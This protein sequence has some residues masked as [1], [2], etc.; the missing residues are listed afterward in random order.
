MVAARADEQTSRGYWT[1]GRNDAE[2]SFRAA[3]KHSRRV[4]RLRV[5]VPAGLIVILGGMLLWSWL[6]PLHLL[7]RLPGRIGD[8]VISGTKITMQAPRLSGF[9][10][11]ARPYE[12]TAKSAAQD[13]T[14]P[15]IVE[16]R[17]IHA[18]VQTLS[19]GMTNITARDGLYDS[20]KEILTLGNDVVLVTA[21]YKAWLTNAVID[22]RSSN[23]VSDKPVKVEI[24]QGILN[25]NRLQVSESG[26]LMTFDGGVV[27]DLQL[28]N[29]APP[30]AQNRPAARNETAPR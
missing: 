13:L 16:L 5:M 4:R 26:Q 9:T 24:L 21:D 27:M 28:E 11:D 12:L 19:N 7:D 14:R 3:R 29:P 18:K 10:R 20:K 2:R 30:A 17:E 1:M 23:V 8:M 15:D 6:N 25:A 22:I